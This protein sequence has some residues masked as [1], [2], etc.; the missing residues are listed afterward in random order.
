M[1]AAEKESAISHHSHGNLPGAT[2]RA[3]AIVRRCRLHPFGADLA[4]LVLAALVGVDLLDE[5][6]RFLMVSVGI[7]VQF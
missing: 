3:G 4:E 5:G 1:P 6:G 7:I 2:G